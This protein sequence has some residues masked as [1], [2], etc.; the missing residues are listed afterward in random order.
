VAIL[1]AIVS[2]ENG[3]CP[4]NQLD[5]VIFIKEAGQRNE[6]GRVTAQ[7]CTGE[8]GTV[9]T[10]S[11]YVGRVYFKESANI[12]GQEVYS[13]FEEGNNTTRHV[14]AIEQSA[15]HILEFINVNDLS[16]N[17][18]APN[19]TFVSPF[20]IITNNEESDLVGE[21][22]VEL[23]GHP[24]QLILALNDIN[25]K[26]GAKTWKFFSAQDADSNDIPLD[27]IEWECFFDN[28]YT[29]MKGNRFKYNPKG[30]LCNK[31]KEFFDDVNNPSNVYGTYRIETIGENPVVVLEVI[32]GPDKTREERVEVLDWNPEDWSTI[33][34]KVS[35]PDDDRE[36]IAV[37]R[38]SKTV[39]WSEF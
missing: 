12:E 7:A 25:D 36:V 15:E 26:G 24:L 37:M 30:T 18:N 17:L 11:E 8:N 3:E 14:E 1:I 9:T 2:C 38:V 4:F 29:Y 10:N 35:H 39:E 23:T 16:N 22:E 34:I 33:T 5:Y 27:D 21:A 20:D 32:E 13:A 6:V 28:T 31:E 19:P